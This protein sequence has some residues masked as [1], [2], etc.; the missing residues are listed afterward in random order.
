MARTLKKWWLISSEGTSTC[1]A[2]HYGMSSA[3]G[4]TL[5]DLPTDDNVPQGSDC[6]DFTKKVLHTFLVF[7][8]IK[9]ADK[10]KE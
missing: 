9:E 4:C 2:N 3:A 8:G 5:E 1:G 10:W 7:R 6:F